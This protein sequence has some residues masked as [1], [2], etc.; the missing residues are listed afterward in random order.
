ML[1][2]L[3]MARSLTRVSSLPTTSSNVSGRYFS[4][5]GTSYPAFFGSFVGTA[6]AAAEATDVAMVDKAMRF[7]TPDI[8]LAELGGRARVGGCTRSH[9]Y[10]GGR[11]GARSSHHTKWTADEERCH[12]SL[13]VAM[14]LRV[15]VWP[16]SS[17]RSPLEPE[18]PGW[19]VGWKLDDTTVVCA[20]IL[21]LDIVCDTR[22]ILGQWKAGVRRKKSSL[23]CFES[24]IDGPWYRDDA[25][26]SSQTQ[27]QLLLYRRGEA[28]YQH[29]VPWISGLF[30]KLLWCVNQ[31]NSVMERLE[32]G[33]SV[34]IEYNDVLERESDSSSSTVE[35][36]EGAEPVQ[37][38]VL[39]RVQ[40]FVLKQSMLALHQTS[41]HS[42]LLQ[43]P[44][45]QLCSIL[46][47]NDKPVTRQ[48]SRRDQVDAYIERFDQ[49]VTIALNMVLGILAGI[50]ICYNTNEILYLLHQTW[51]I[52]YEEL[53][54]DNIRWLETFPAGF[55]LNVP[56]TQ[57]M[58]REITVLI[59]IHDSICDVLWSFISKTF[60]LQT[61]GA[62]SILFGFTALIALLHDMLVL[63]TIHIATVA[64]CFRV[65][66]RTQ[67][68]L[69]ASLWR[70]FR[71]R[72]KNILRHRT[73]SMEYDSMQLLVGMFLFTTVL[74]LFTTILVYYAFF[75]ILYLAIQSIGVVLWTIFMIPRFLPLGKC[76][77]RVRHPGWFIETIYLEDVASTSRTVSKLTPV[78]RSYASILSDPLA[79]HFTAVI[80][81]IPR[82]HWRCTS[83]KSVHC[84]G[85]L[86]RRNSLIS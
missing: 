36:R 51:M 14:A 18:K 83:W 74:F 69:L 68:Y 82:A 31:A 81:S 37:S 4:T 48:I 58:G 6:A 65:M 21:P 17:D 43:I 75:T 84:S 8:S 3:A 41:A 66:H 33:E 25:D 80:S 32:C 47:S 46:R 15:L 70:L 53:L 59:G 16:E 67:L 26:N 45:V 77:L 23:L 10:D 39:S 72:K 7:P 22:M 76:L 1:P 34:S 57:N 35:K 2:S 19:V 29:D 24:T 44:M 85:G 30:P 12:E 52:C 11:H 49:S 64:T 78:Y 62:A 50:T 71:G 63:A 61:I 5:Q 40:R 79:S 73:D 28:L 20:G 56:L 9:T 27:Q 60:V 13:D 42:P 38:N 86:S 55:K 54:C